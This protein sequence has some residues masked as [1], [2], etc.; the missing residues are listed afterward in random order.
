MRFRSLFVAAALAAAG[1]AHA[2]STPVEQ[3]QIIEGKGLTDNYVYLGMPRKQ[4]AALDRGC[5]GKVTSC[6]FQ[7]QAGSTTQLDTPIVTLHFDAKNK[8]SS[9]DIN[10]GGRAIQWPTTAGATNAMSAAEVQALYPGSTLV[11]DEVFNTNT[12]TA[13][14]Q[15]YVFSQAFTC[16]PFEPCG[17]LVLHSVVKPKKAQ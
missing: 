2:Q 16:A 3:W 4:A 6:S 1:A 11:R 10:Q 8:V 17:V 13:A 5:R 9:I 12:V 14:K 7:P 15:G